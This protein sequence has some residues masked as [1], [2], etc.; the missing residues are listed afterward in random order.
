M[1]SDQVPYRITRLSIDT[2]PKTGI[3]ALGIN[4]I[5]AC[6]HPN[7]RSYSLQCHINRRE[8]K[9]AAVSCCQENSSGPLAEGFGS[10]H[11]S[12][13]RFRVSM[14]YGVRRPCHHVIGF[15]L[16]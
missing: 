8:D 6:I 1:W 16:E 4:M 3:K 10:Y 14:L 7:T 11:P 2:V 12:S 5:N 9:P 15:L 13:N